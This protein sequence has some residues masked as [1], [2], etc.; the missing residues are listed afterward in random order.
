[1][2]LIN[3]L[4]DYPLDSVTHEAKVILL[5]VRHS[6]LIHQRQLTTCILSDSASCHCDCVSCSTHISFGFN[7]AS[8]K[9]TF[10]CYW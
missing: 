7:V 9:A 3:Y 6:A 1:M 5:W 8:F 2:M 4:F 10:N